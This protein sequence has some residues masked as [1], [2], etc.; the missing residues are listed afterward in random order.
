MDDLT[1]YFMGVAAG[2]FIT[3]LMCI[4]FSLENNDDAN[5]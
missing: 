4:I 2:G 5:E 3:L 1:G